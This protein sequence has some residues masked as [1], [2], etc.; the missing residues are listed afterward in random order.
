LVSYANLGGLGARAGVPVVH[1]W[2]PPPPEPPWI[3]TAAPKSLGILAAT[4]ILLP[5]F[6]LR[7]NRCAAAWWI[8]L[9]VGISGLAGVTIVCL[10]SDSDWSL[11]QAVGA[12]VV[13]LVAMWLLMPFLGSRYR[14]VAFCKALPVL[15]GFSLLAFVPTLLAA[16][17]GW[18]DFRPH[19]AALLALG[20]LSV[21]LALTF[22]GQS[23]RHRFGRIRFLFWLAVWTLLAWTVIASAFVFIRSLNH[24]FDWG[25]SVV[26][27]LVI[28]G[29]TLVLI[30]P[31][32]LLSFFQPMYR[33]RMFGFL[34]VPQPG[35]SAGATVPLGMAD[36]VQSR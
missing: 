28:T 32:V 1:T 19:L 6:L 36:V 17:S 8:W 12:F 18:L 20:S 27:L 5:L 16:N 35:R 34:H 25:E 21:T 26:A 7:P 4:L 9:P 2:E 14:T 11:A 30:L 33:A 29:L 10:M 3:I 22:G 15:A 31:L 13:G 23:V 24:P